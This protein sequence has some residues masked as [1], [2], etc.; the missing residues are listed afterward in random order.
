MDT[1]PGPAASEPTLLEELRQKLAAKGPL[2]IQRYPELW[3]QLDR[4]IKRLEQLE[5]AV[6]E[7][8]GKADLCPYLVLE[9]YCT[10]CSCPTAS[11]GGA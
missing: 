5:K 3:V 6:L 2:A 4:T 10:D 9:R 1:N 7:F 11:C 8:A